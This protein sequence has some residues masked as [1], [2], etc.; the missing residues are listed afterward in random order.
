MVDTQGLV[1]AGTWLELTGP[2]QAP[3][4]VLQTHN[5]R[6]QHRVVARMP[7]APVMGRSPQRLLAHDSIE[8]WIARQMQASTVTLHTIQEVGTPTW[9]VQACR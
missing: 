4:W 2:G 8:G 7:A 3:E 6:G 1:S 5:R 9:H